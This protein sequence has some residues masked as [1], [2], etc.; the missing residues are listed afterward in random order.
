M[1]EENQFGDLDGNVGDPVFLQKLLQRIDRDIQA[2]K[3]ACE[4]LTGCVSGIFGAV[5]HM[6]DESRSTRIAGPMRK[7]LREEIDEAIAI[8]GPHPFLKRMRD[9]C[10]GDP[11]VPQIVP[12]DG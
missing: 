2:T 11:F 1:E 12:K 8:L 4:I 6:G 5:E 10:G 9:T 3:K 7:R